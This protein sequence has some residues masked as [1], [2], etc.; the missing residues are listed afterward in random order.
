[1]LSQ[2]QR[3]NVL[4]DFVYF[5][6]FDMRSAFV[7]S[8]IHSGSETGPLAKRVSAIETP[9]Q[10]ALAAIK[11]LAD[12]YECKSNELFQWIDD[13]EQFVLTGELSRPDAWFE[14]QVPQEGLIR[15]D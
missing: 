8:Q 11:R 15:A 3:K 4:K 12:L 14:L 2:G 7:G 13:Y 6:E 1:L 10:E 9:P 5:T